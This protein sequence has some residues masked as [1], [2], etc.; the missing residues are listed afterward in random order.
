MEHTARDVLP[1]FA[2]VSNGNPHR[3]LRASPEQL[4]LCT[5]RCIMSVMG[6]PRSFDQDEVR[7]ALL[8]QFWG[9]G[10]NGSSLPDLEAAAGLTRKSL[11]NAF[12]DKRTMFLHALRDFRR[13]AVVTNTDPLQAKGASL[14]AIEQVL[15]GLAGYAQTADGRLG[16][17]VCNTAREDVRDDPAVKAEIDAYFRQLEHRF[18]AAIQ[19]GQAQ[20]KITDRSAKDLARLCVG[21]VVSISVLSKAGQSVAVLRSIASETVAALTYT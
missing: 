21:A 11:Y 6:R 19:H 18:L 16:C 9:H 14:G 15:Y 7:S 13:T 1:R 8:K 4:T 12:G 10:Y 2:F 20:G 3:I 17:M 5:D